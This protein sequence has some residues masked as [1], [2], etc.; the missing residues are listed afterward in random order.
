[1]EH[2]LSLWENVE[3][4]L[5]LL[6]FVDILD[7]ELRVIYNAVDNQPVEVSEGQLRCEPRFY[8]GKPFRVVNRI[9]L[10]EQEKLFGIILIVLF[11]ATEILLMSNLNL[12]LLGASNQ[13]FKNITL[14]QG[15]F[16][17]EVVQVI[18]AL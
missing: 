11:Q 7:A 4:K 17:T 16:L 3:A 13:T 2:C 8:I 15:S 5:Q 1:V 9:Q 6:L 14:I 12:V 10:V 18:V